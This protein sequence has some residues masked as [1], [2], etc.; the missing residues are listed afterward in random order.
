MKQYQW[1]STWNI[2]IARSVQNAVFG[3]IHEIVIYYAQNN[4][5]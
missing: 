4:Y 1:R 3:W 2:L 5:L